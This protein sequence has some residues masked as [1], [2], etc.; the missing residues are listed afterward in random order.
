MFVHR[1]PAP[2]PSLL[3]LASAHTHTTRHLLQFFHLGQVKSVAFTTH[4]SLIRIF[5]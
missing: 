2:P 3:T 5:T 4:A 1:H